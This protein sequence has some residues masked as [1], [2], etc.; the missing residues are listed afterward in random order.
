MSSELLRYTMTFGHVDSPDT[1]EEVVKLSDHE[2][3]LA[4]AVAAERKRCRC[5]NLNDMVL[6]RLTD[7][8]NKVF[9]QYY[10]NLNL[11]P[12]EYR[13]M[14]RQ[15]DGRYGMQLWEVMKIF[16]SECYMG[17]EIPIKTEIEVLEDP[18]FAAVQ[19]IQGELP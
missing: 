15:P 11:C 8:G 9:D 17:P 12:D 19:Q 3:A 6:I 14:Y 16:G 1:T 7:R 10:A 13:E 4:A 2:Q 18:L 5:V